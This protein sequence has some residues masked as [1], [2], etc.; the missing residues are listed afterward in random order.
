MLQILNKITDNNLL[1]FLT[2]QNNR[3]RFLFAEDKTSGG[4]NIFM[5][6]QIKCLDEKYNGT[7]DSHKHTLESWTGPVFSLFFFFSFFFFILFSFFLFY[8]YKTCTLML[9]DS[10]G[11]KKETHK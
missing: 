3:D 6:G 10:Q 11:Q 5:T 7:S 4:I 9:T 8:K 1:Y 2:G